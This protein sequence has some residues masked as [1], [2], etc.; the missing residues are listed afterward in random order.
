MCPSRSWPSTLH[1]CTFEECFRDSKSLRFGMGQE[2]GRS[3]SALRLHALLLIATLASF[4]T[5]HIESA[6]RGQG[7]CIVT[8][9]R[10]TRLKRE[11]SLI[12]LA[13]LVGALPLLHLSEFAIHALYERL[14]TQWRKKPG[15]HQPQPSPSG[16]GGKRR[17][18]RG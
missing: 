1:A 5:W 6:R 11:L 7:R 14:D 9:R 17:P 4:P 13:R 8:S 18:S 2:L 10:T 12:S 15:K 3:R 16:R